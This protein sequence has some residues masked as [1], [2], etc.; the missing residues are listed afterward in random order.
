M[1]FLNKKLE[2]RG[3]SK[4][5]D[6]PIFCDVN[7]ALTKGQIISIV[8]SSGVGK[9]TLFNIVAGLVSPTTGQVFIDGTNITGQAGFVGYMLQ[10]D[11]LLPFKAV[12][13]NIALP[14]VLKGVNELQIKSKIDS[15]VDA[16]GL[17]GLIHKYPHLLSGGQRQ[18]AALLRT[19]L[20]NNNVMLLDEPFSALDY[21]TKREMYDW[22]MK[23]KNEIGLTCLVITHDIDEAVFL[24][25][26]I[27]VLKGKPALLSKP[28]FINKDVDFATSKAY[29]ILKEAILKEIRTEHAN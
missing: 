1:T 11:L 21:V 17:S 5:F 14:L 24:S 7:L 28:F 19:Y 8:G 25:D 18:R 12:Y 15:Y 26:V 6:V 2:L 3:I 27:Y 22:F 16:F 13:D 9:T 23:F 29:L 20:S 10:K 4:V